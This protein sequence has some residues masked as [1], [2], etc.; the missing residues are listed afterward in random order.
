MIRSV[1]NASGC[2][3]AYTGRWVDRGGSALRA[4]GRP[5]PAQVAEAR[6]P[7]PKDEATSVARTS[8]HHGR[9]SRREGRTTPN[10][11]A[12][13]LAFFMPV[14]AYIATCALGG[15]AFRDGGSVLTRA[16]ARASRQATRRHLTLGLLTPSTSAAA[17]RFNLRCAGVE[18]IVQMSQPTQYHSKLFD[19]ALT[20]LKV[21]W[22]IEPAYQFEKTV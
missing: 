13:L 21:K 4:A 18:A 2:R 11:I 8:A 17:A 10:R 19:S 3:G 20:E 5:P 1:T 16:G 7:T 15:G 9:A 6:R 12:I 14:L 22:E